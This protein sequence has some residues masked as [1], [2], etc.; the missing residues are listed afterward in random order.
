MT[1]EIPFEASL[2]KIVA[3]LRETT[4]PS[5]I[6]QRSEILVQCYNENLRLNSAM[7]NAFDRIQ[8]EWS[9]DQIY[10]AETRN[11]L[12]FIFDLFDDMFKCYYQIFTNPTIEPLKVR[13]LDKSYYIP[14]YYLPRDI[15]NGIKKMRTQP[16]PELASM[17]PEVY[18]YVVRTLDEEFAKLGSTFK[19]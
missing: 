2:E 14:E 11:C 1:Y 10:L 16:C 8:A 9:Q 4:A 17:R 5:E 18:A 6:V 7:N 12:Y 3:V 19:S 13:N 15:E